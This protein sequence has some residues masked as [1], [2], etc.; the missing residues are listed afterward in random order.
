MIEKLNPP[1]SPLRGAIVG[2]GNVAHHAHLPVWRRNRHF[3]IEAVLEPDP[4]R[5][6]IAEQLLPEARIHHTLSGLLAANNLNFLDICCPPCFHADLVVSACQSGLHVFC[7]KPLATSL[8]DLQRISTAAQDSGR[9][10]FTVNNWKYA[11]IW[12]KA[13]ELIRAGQIGTV[14]SVALHVLRPPNS[15]GGH[16]N[17]RKSKQIAGGGIL[18]DHGWHNLYLL[19]T[20]IDEPPISIKASMTSAR[21]STAELEETVDVDL[22]FPGAHAT[23]HLTW[24]AACRQNCGTVV[25]DKGMLAVNDD[26]LILE[27]QDTPPIRYDFPQALSAGSH[28][29]AWMEPVVADFAREIN[30]QNGHGRNLLEA[31]RCAQ[32]IHLAYLSHQ[33]GARAIPVTPLIPQASPL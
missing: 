26:H 28:H 18:I 19:L 7:E 25:G 30:G 33:Q 13:C 21:D 1:P 3:H 31:Q 17:W 20:L 5:A 9:V 11:P 6:K 4:E 29:T 27:V 10:V 22:E 8:P 12:L 2:F 16:T 23:L 32:L 15:G 14:R 24:Q